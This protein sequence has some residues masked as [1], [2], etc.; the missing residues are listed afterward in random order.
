MWEDEDN[1]NGGR[2][3]VRAQKQKRVASKWWEDIVLALIGD[4][5]EAGDEICGVVC[6]RC[7]FPTF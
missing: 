6:F 3:M 7:L 5:F 4:Q 1:K 2:F